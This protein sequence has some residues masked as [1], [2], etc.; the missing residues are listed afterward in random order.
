MYNL[1]ESIIH[2]VFLAFQDKKRKKEYIDMSF[3][4]IMVGAMLKS[5]GYSDRIVNIGYLH[6]VIEDTDYTYEDISTKFGKDIADGVKEVSELSENGTWREKKEKFF[7]NLEKSS[8]DIIAVELADKLQNLLSDYELFLANGEN[9]LL[10][11]SDNLDN[12]KWYYTS[13]Q[14]L[15]N[16]R[17]ENNVLLDRYNNIIEVYFGK[18]S[19]NN[20][21]K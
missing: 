5:A 13:L 7:K 14:K 16:D 17:L 11:E 12:F 21:K 4:S 10:T 18:N 6:D 20:I 1:E 15:F 19:K 3:H 2:F 8:N 9:S